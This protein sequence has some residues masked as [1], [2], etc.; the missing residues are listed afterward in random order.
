MSNWK[1]GALSDLSTGFNNYVSA[2]PEYNFKTTRSRGFVGLKTSIFSNKD[3]VFS[4]GGVAEFD[5]NSTIHIE[6]NYKALFIGYGFQMELER[7]VH[8]TGPL[9]FGLGIATTSVWGSGSTK[10]ENYTRNEKSETSGKYSRLQGAFNTKVLCFLSSK[11]RLAFHLN[12]NPLEF[13]YL[14]ISGSSYHLAGIKQVDKNVR[15]S[16]LNQFS[17]GL[18]YS[19]NGMSFMAQ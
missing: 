2:K 18:V 7:Y 12:F 10:Y 14:E 15:V 13:N 11:K 6:S 1:I 8:V 3:M 5:E 9:Y 19:L 4:L 16:L 17:F